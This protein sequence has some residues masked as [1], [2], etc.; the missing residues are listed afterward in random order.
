GLDAAKRV[1]AVKAAA[2]VEGGMRVGLGT[3][4]TTAFAIEELGRRIREEDL[5][6]LG[7]PTS[8]SASILARRHGV[9]VRSLDELGGLDIALDGADEV[10]PRLDL[11]KGRGAAHTREKVVATEASRFVVLVDE[12]K[13]VDRLGSRMPVPIEVVPMAAGSVSRRVQ[14]L[15]GLP[16]LREGARKDGPVVTDQ[17]FWIIDATFDVIADAA[18]LDRALHSMPGVLEH[19][20]FIGLATDILVGAADGSVEHLTR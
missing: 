1:A 15:G 5:D 17:G 16:E 13:I 20:L 14:A 4:S 6:I 2:L 7:T 9:P 11:I 12:S 8:P 19:G 10:D 3:G 18:E